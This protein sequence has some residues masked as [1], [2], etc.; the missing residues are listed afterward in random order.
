MRMDED[1]LVGDTLEVSGS[2][3]E[4]LAGN[5]LSIS[6]LTRPTKTKQAWLGLLGAL[7]QHTLHCR[8]II[9]VGGW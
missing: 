7:F 2:L 8:N 5:P 9:F 1:G 6:D 4:T 3:A